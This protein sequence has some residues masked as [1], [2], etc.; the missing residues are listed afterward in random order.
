MERNPLINQ[1]F[2]N[3]MINIINFDSEINLYLII[4]KIIEQKNFS[5]IMQIISFNL[6]N[7]ILN[8]SETKNEEKIIENL[9]NKYKK[10]EEHKQ[11]IKNKIKKN[12]EKL[13]NNINKNIN[14]SE[15]NKNNKIKNNLNNI[16][17]LIKTDQIEYVKNPNSIE[18]KRNLIKQ[19]YEI[20]EAKNGS[21]IIIPDENGN[22]YSYHLV[23][24]ESKDFWNL[25]CSNADCS[26]K[27]KINKRNLN[28]VLIKNHNL[29]Y[30][31][32]NIFKNFEILNSKY[33]DN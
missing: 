13:S 28:C 2:K 29:P 15:I 4:Q 27:V 18:Q 10:E 31:K 17:N 33:Y 25:K 5:D 24:N 9:I 19:K 16:P 3:I 26:A 22:K 23:T 32:H 7:N 12:I 20:I 1:F 11:N 14:D 8:F 30:I 6:Y 21:S